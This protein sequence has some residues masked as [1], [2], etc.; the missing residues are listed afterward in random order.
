MREAVVEHPPA[1]TWRDLIRDPFNHGRERFISTTP[2]P[3]GAK[4]R[5]KLERTS[6][7]VRNFAIF[8]LPGVSSKSSRRHKFDE[9]A[10]SLMRRV[11]WER[12]SRRKRY[13]I[14][15]ECPT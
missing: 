8:V 1:V 4:Q 10:H 11:L 12:C 6:F 14:S 5:F 2:G 13:S 7:Y 3:G 15:A 9:E